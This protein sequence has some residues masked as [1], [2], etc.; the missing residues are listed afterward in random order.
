MET[1]GHGEAEEGKAKGSFT[2]TNQSYCIRNIFGPDQ[3][4][5]DA[6][7]GLKERT[8]ANAHEDAIAV[9]CGRRGVGR[10]GICQSSSV[11][12]RCIQA[13][14]GFMLHIKDA[15]TIVK[16]PPQRYQG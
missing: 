13:E 15:P 3:R 10:N 16:P 4:L 7:T 14:R 8:G 6:E 11:R 5:R 12:I 9:H 2:D 1:Y